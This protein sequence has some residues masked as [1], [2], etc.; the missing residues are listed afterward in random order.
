MNRYKALNSCFNQL[1]RKIFLQS[2]SIFQERYSS[3]LKY[4][5]TYRRFIII[6]ISLVIIVSGYL[7]Y[8]NVLKALTLYF[9]QTDWSGGADTNTTIDAT[10]ST[11]WTKYYSQTGG[12]DT[13]TVGEIKLK[14]EVTQP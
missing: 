6:S 9:T 7:Y 8:A 5:S 2:I 3:H 12:I 11:G 1:V 14:L 13:T 4:V 10:N